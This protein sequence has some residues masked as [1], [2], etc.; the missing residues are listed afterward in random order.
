MVDL[1]DSEPSGILCMTLGHTMSMIKNKYIYYF[2]MTYLVQAMF[3]IV[4]CV[5]QYPTLS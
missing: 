5:E 3:Q 2:N 4:C 1:V